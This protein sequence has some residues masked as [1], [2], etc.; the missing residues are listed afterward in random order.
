M[1]YKVN[2]PATA[3]AGLRAKAVPAQKYRPKKVQP[4]RGGY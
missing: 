2:A 4:K 3:K 1:S